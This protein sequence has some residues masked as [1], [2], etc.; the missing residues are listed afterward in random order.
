[1]SELP[2]EGRKALGVDYGLVVEDVSGGAAAG[3]GLERGDVIVA[4]GQERFRSLEEFNKLLARRKGERVPSAGAS[5]RER[6][7]C[8]AGTHLR[9]SVHRQPAGNA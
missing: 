4:V 5:R 2:P 3:S 7:V 1:M 8:S 6:A 9:L